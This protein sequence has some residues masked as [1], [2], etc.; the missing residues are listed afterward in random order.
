MSI[1]SSVFPVAIASIHAQ[2]F[3]DPVLAKPMI[4]RKFLGNGYD[5]A[6]GKNTTSYEDTEIIAVE[7]KHTLD[8]VS[9]SSAKVEVG[10]TLFLVEY[11]SLPFALSLKDTLIDPADGRE[12]AFK[13][14]DPMFNILHSITVVDKRSPS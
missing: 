8:S 13:G 11:A 9:K 5:P 12:Y 1:S 6:T 14:L 4:Y 7:M 10:M 2:L 3:V